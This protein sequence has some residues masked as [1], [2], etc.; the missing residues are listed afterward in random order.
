M[1]ELVMTREQTA[2]LRNAKERV[3]LRSPEGDVLGVVSEPTE[4]VVNNEAELIKEILEEGGKP[5]RWYT[6]DEVF[7]HLHSLETR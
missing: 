3:V 5:Q 6:T 4:N 1:V 2:T 7:A